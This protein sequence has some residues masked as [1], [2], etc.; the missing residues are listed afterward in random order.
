MTELKR[1]SSQRTQGASEG[2]GAWSDAELD[3]LEAAHAEGFTTNQVIELFQGRGQRLSEATFRKYVQLGLL[4]RSV[5]VG[6]KGKNRGSQGVYP[7]TVV[8]QIESV[9]RLMAQGLTIDEI[10]GEFLFLRNEIDDL[11][12]SLEQVLSALEASTQSTTDASSATS[13]DARAVAEV[14]ALGD[15]LVEKL[16]GVQRRLAMRARM[17]RA[18][19]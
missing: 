17:A 15:E 12:R 2:A 16:R 8:R 6:R 18:A 9:R 14:R 7:P 1:N 19:V 3:G 11:A 10:R 4:P 5:R 13:V